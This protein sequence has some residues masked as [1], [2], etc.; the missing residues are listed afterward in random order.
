M[1][2]SFLLSEINLYNGFYKVDS[3]FVPEYLMTLAY[4]LWYIYDMTFSTFFILFDPANT[5][6]V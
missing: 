6:F 2:I 1:G 3:D 4:R 5:P